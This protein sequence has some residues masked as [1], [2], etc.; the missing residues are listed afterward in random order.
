MSIHF[1]PSDWNIWTG[2]YY[3]AAMVIG[4]TTS[5]KA[6]A[7]LQAAIQR[8]WSDNSLRAYALQDPT[9]WSNSDSLELEDLALDEIL[10]I[11]G[12]FNHG[13]L[14]QLPF[15]TVVVREDAPDGEDWLYA[16]VPL[17]GVSQSDGYPFGDA[18]HTAAS[19]SWRE[20][21]EQALANL[22]LGVCDVV[23]IRIAAIGFEISGNIERDPP[24]GTRDRRHEG[25]ICREAAGYRYLPTTAW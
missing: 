11:Y 13:A 4:N 7:S 15:V 21:L 17:G 16:G 10:R 1:D 23:P 2:G 9:H 22:A 3:E 6:D 25:Y 19:R 5:N 18:E 12:V 14:G 20:P 24:P 8:L